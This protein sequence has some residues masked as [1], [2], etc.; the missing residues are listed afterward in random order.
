[1]FLRE[2]S[3]F[4][5]F[6]LKFSIS[7]FIIIFPVMIHFFVVLIL[8]NILFAVILSYSEAKTSIV[9]TMICR[10]EEVNLRANLAQW[11]PI[12]DYFIFLIDSRTKDNT[13]KVIDSIFSAS[14]VNRFKTVTYEFEG[15]GQARTLVSQS[16]KIF[17]SIDF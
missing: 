16:L 5:F 2:R 1:L 17:Y 9:M 13:W 4:Y 14:K 10:D 15:F 12:I 7:H 3:S 11:F 6:S 8:S